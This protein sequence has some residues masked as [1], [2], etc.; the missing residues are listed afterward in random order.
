MSGERL[1]L[2]WIQSA[3]MGK[4]SCFLVLN[5][6]AAELVIFNVG[7]GYKYVKTNERRVQTNET[8]V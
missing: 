2:M 5:S 6:I 7:L 1:H 4:R 8:K 3:L